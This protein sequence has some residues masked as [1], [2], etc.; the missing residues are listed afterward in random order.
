M[1]DASFAFDQPGSYAPGQ[2][3]GP[4]DL[5]TERYGG[6]S[7]SGLRD[8]TDTVFGAAPLGGQARHGHPHAASRYAPMGGGVGAAGQGQGQGQFALMKMDEMDTYFG[9]KLEEADMGFSPLGERLIR[10]DHQ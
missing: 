7:G 10:K 5:S 8:P 9:G 3:G 4:A 6:G 2:A 1:S